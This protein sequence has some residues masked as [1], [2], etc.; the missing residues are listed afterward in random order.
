M[1]LPWSYHAYHGIPLCFNAV[2]PQCCLLLTHR[3]TFRRLIYFDVFRFSLDG[4]SRLGSGLGR[5]RTPK[6]RKSSVAAS[7]FTWSRRVPVLCPILLTGRGYSSRDTCMVCTYEY[8]DVL[9]QVR[10]V[11]E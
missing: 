5:I 3:Y 9:T 4:S 7:V 8:V 1:V 10:I 2:D 11:V 6:P